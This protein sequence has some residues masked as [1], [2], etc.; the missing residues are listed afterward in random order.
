MQYTI[1]WANATKTRLA[2]PDEYC[3]FAHST[4]DFAAVY[5][6]IATDAMPSRIALTAKYKKCCE[7]KL[8]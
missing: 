3:F 5:E 2:P 1:S 4:D 7:G 8:I 6:R